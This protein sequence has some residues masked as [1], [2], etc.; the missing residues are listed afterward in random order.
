MINGFD[1]PTR[2][3]DL[4]D[5]K[6]LSNVT[7]KGNILIVSKD[8]INVTNTANLT[9]VIVSAPFVKVMSGFKGNIQII[10]KDSVNI[11]E[12]VTMLYPSA[13]YIKNDNN[14]ASFIIK[15]N[16]ILVGGIVVTGEHTLNNINR[17]VTIQEKASVIGNIYC[18]GG[19]QLEGLVTGTIYTDRF[20]LKTKSSYYENVILNG[21]INR[22]SLP[23]NFIE[24][25][26]FENS[27]NNT[28]Y[29]IIKKI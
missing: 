21:A 10:A 24:L 25:P 17:S 18:Q 20:F 11:E 16:S 5:T 22:D 27:Y 13:V 2:I 14:K 23:K 8:K 9:D 4:T 28:K 29:A 3:I 7:C 15:N 1:K 12:D 19:T 6:E 26:L